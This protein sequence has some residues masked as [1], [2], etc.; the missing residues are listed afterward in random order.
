[1]NADERGFLT[2]KYAKHTNRF[3]SDFDSAISLAREVL[4]L[5]NAKH[6]PP[7]YFTGLFHRASACGMR[8]IF[9]QAASCRAEVGRRRVCFPNFFF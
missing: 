5:W 1:M 2:A 4:G 9:Q 7:G 6:I 8:S 3:I